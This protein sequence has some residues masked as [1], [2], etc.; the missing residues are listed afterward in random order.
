MGAQCGSEVSLLRHVLDAEGRA[1]AQTLNHRLAKGARFPIKTCPSLEGTHLKMSIARLLELLAR[2][3][4]AALFILDG[5]EHLS[6]KQLSALRRRASKPLGYPKLLVGSL[7][8][9]RAEPDTA[10]GA[11]PKP[12][13]STQCLRLRVKTVASYLTEVSCRKGST[14]PRPILERLALPKTEWPEAENLALAL[15]LAR[16]EGM[17]AATQ[18]PLA[19]LFALLDLVTVL[20]R[21]SSAHILVLDHIHLADATDPRA[22]DNYTKPARTLATLSARTIYKRRVKAEQ[23]TRLR[24]LP[25]PARDRARTAAAHRLA[26]KGGIEQAHQDD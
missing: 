6:V 21:G 3:E 7:K 9:A 12:S 19:L 14:L 22:L 24:Q 16:F 20:S 23:Q 25:D 1:L 18:L 5:E 26:R 4:T 17:G 8:N 10:S 15:L 13:K 2:H 11:D